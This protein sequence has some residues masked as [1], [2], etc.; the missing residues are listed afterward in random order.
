MPTAIWSNATSLVDEYV[1]EIGGP[2]IFKR[3]QNR[4]PP[5]RSD[6]DDVVGPAR[7]ARTPPIARCRCCRA[8]SPRAW[9][10]A[11]STSRTCSRRSG[12]RRSTTVD[13][14][15]RVAG[16]PRAQHDVRRHV[17]RRRRPHPAGRAHP[18]LH[19]RGSDPRARVR[20][21]RARAQSGHDRHRESAS[22]SPKSFAVAPATRPACRALAVD[23]D[24]SAARL[25]SVLAA[26]RRTGRGAALPHLADRC[27]EPALAVE[28]RL[29]PPRHV[30]RR[31]R[32]LLPRA[33]HGRRD[34]ALPDAELRV[35][36]RRRGVGRDA[37]Q[38]H[39]RAFR[40]A[41]RR[42]I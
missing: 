8:I 27:A 39:R 30:R 24:R 1:R 32:A 28:L 41:Q 3:W 16:V 37:A 12:S 31:G 23:R 26:L 33:L 35:A 6:Q 19:A 7:R 14:E 38:R 2:E 29:Q 13:D 11:A 18:D 25:R 36:R 10:S 9:T 5:L 20:G 22:R 17:P 40:E 42:P 34:A 15:L 4:P 21:A